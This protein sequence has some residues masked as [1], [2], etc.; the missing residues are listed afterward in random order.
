MLR[1]PG[2]VSLWI[3]H[4]TRKLTQDEQKH[5]S[6]GDSARANAKNGRE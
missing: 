5:V 2:E 1:I 6:T 3:N 4:E